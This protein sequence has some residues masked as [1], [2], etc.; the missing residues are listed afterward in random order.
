MKQGSNTLL[1]V[2]VQPTTVYGQW[3][4]G[5]YRSPKLA[6]H[7][8]SNALPLP[9]R[10]ALRPVMPYMHVFPILWGKAKGIR[11]FAGN[12]VR[13]ESL[14]PRGTKKVNKSGGRRQNSRSNSEIAGQGE[15]QGRETMG[16]TR[17]TAGS[18]FRRVCK[19]FRLPVRCMMMI[20]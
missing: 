17:V 10:S 7:H 9:L 20:P 19:A 18:N 6:V 16:A 3:H 13:D 2:L 14:P 5:R 11:R 15:G 1:H 4:H 12:E 8:L